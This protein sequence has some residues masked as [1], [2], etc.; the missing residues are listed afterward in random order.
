MIH[1]AP[2]PPAAASPIYTANSHSDGRKIGIH[3]SVFIW[4]RKARSKSGW[5]DIAGTLMPVLVRDRETFTQVKKKNR[6]ASN[7][8]SA[9]KWYIEA[10]GGQMQLNSRSARDSQHRHACR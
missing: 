4:M 3:S 6:I 10:S 8:T 9:V 5:P 7:V 1:T 2:I